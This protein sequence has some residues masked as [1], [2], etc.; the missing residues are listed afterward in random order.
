MESSHIRQF[1]SF[2]TF[3]TTTAKYALEQAAQGSMFLGCSG[4]SSRSKQSWQDPSS[5][6]KI[7]TTREDQDPYPLKRQQVDFINLFDSER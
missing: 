7:C 4:A 1:S 2:R 5:H 3:A 6:G